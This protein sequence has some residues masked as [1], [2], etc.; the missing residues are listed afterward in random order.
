M[1]S[2]RH[3]NLS[4]LFLDGKFVKKIVNLVNICTDLGINKFCARY[5]LQ[6]LQY[7]DKV[8]PPQRAIKCCLFQCPI[9]FRFF[10]VMK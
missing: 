2:A 8:H 10:N 6:I 4:Y 9:Y 1:I 3:S 5:V 7:S